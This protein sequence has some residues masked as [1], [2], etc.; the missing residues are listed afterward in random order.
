LKEYLDDKESLESRNLDKMRAL[1]SNPDK[2]LSGSKISL[3]R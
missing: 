1:N 3:G 2:K